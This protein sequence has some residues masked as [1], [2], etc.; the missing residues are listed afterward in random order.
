MI[1]VK[2]LTT[3]LLVA[4]VLVATDS[5]AN[6]AVYRW[7]DDRGIVHFSDLPGQSAEATKVEVDAGSPANSP[8]A[9]DSASDSAF[10]SPAGP[11]KAQQQ[12]EERENRQQ[13][14]AKK[15][16]AIA[17]NCKQ[18]RNIVA[19][20]EPF[21]R[22]MVRG[23][24]GEVYRMDDKDRLESLSEAKTYIAENCVD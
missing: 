9:G 16:A 11:S 7:V 4:L 12:R 21:T 22:V 24:D 6:E 10:A 3:V 8:S 1:S 23:E 18:R 5:V 15:K 2:S 19:K 20:L 13:D 14:T 17:A